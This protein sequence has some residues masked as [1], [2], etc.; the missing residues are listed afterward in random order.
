MGD[1]FVLYYG[2]LIFE[3]V[4]YTGMLLLTFL[5]TVNRLTIFVFP[6]YNGRLFSVRNTIIM[7]GI[8]WAYILTIIAVNE[9]SGCRKLFS[10][11]EFYF[12]YDCAGQLN[13]GHHYNDFLIYQEYVIATLMGIIYLIVYAKIR[14]SQRNSANVS[15]NEKAFLI[16]TIPLSI[17]FAT[18][19]VAFKFTPTLEITGQYRFFVSAFDNLIMLSLYVASPILLLIFNRDVRKNVSEIISSHKR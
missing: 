8:I 5:I 10:K 9:I 14:I 7:S 19:I 6:R 3:S 2:P 4:A 16:Q 1:S 15:K 11:E 18:E 13:G 17:L 12:W